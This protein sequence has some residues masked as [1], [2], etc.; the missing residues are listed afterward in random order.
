MRN[1]EWGMRDGKAETGN[2]K[3]EIGNWK[4]ETGRTGE[5]GEKS[6]AQQETVC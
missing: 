5:E 3:L 2:R 1:A 4:S 6:L